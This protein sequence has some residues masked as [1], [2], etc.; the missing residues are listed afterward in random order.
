KTK[1]SFAECRKRPA[2]I[3]R[4]Q[5]PEY[6]EKGFVNFKLVGRGLP[7]GLV[8]ESYLY[9]LVK[10]EYRQQVQDR[11]RKDLEKLTGRRPDF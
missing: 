1:P 4:E 2:F 3:S 9:Y 7:I 6:I 10:D 8:V 5:I 11:I